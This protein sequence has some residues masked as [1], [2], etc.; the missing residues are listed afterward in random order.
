MT[1]SLTASIVALSI[2]L[3][4]LS[5]APA[6][7]ASNDDLGRIFAGALTLF[8][9]GKALQDSKKSNNTVSRFRYDDAVRTVPRARHTKKRLPQEC[10]FKMRTDRGSRG[11]YGK[12]CLNELMRHANRLP[13]ACRDTVRVRY[14]RRAEVYGAPCLKRHGYKVAGHRR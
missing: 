8:I 14:G 2:A 3:S 4:S 7:A 12:I 10:Y 5:A 6:R 11:V 9:I 13:R 1:R